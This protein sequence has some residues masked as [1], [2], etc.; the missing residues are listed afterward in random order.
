MPEPRIEDVPP[1]PEFPHQPFTP[2]DV[3]GVVPPGGGGEDDDSEES[4]G[5]VH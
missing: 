3:T 4:P 2:D 1:R 5:A